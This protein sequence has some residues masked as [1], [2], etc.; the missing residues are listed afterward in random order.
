MKKKKNI[1]KIELIKLKS[2]TN[3]HKIELH[4]T[5]LSIQQKNITISITKFYC[6]YK[7]FFVNKQII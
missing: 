5:N 7:V 3:F 6:L 1:K 2:N 4:K